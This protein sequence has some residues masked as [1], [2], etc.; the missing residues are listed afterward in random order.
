M[1]RYVLKDLLKDIE[2]TVLSGDVNREVSCICYDSRDM[3]AGAVFVCIKGANNDS[4]NMAQ[5]T[6][7]Y[8]AAAIVV[9]KEIEIIGDVTVILVKNTRSALSYMSSV[10]FGKPAKK[11]LMIGITGTKGK[12]TT[13]YMIEKILNSVGINTGLIGSIEVRYAD[14]VKANENTTPESYQLQEILYN[15]VNSGVQAVVME[16]SSQGLKLSRVD[17]II[18]DYAIF[19]NLSRDH[20][21]KYEHTDMDEYIA[22]KSMLFEQSR[23]GIFNSDDSYLGRMIENNTCDT[24]SYYGMNYKN[25]GEGVYVCADN[26]ELKYIDGLPGVSF[27]ISIYQEALELTTHNYEIK[28]PGIYSVYNAMAAITVCNSILESDES[29]TRA[30]IMAEVLSEIVVKGRSEVIGTDKGY[31][32]VVDFAHNEMSLNSVLTSMRQYVKGRLICLFGCGGNRSVERRYMMGE[33]SARLADLTVVT[34]DN[35]RYEKP[36]NI[37]KDIELGIL[38]VLNESDRIP[39]EKASF[40]N[41]KYVMID[42]RQKAIEVTLSKAKEGDVIILAGKGHETYQDIMGIKYPMQDAVIVREYLNG[43]EDGKS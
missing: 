40:D 18:F 12:T 9:E 36:E 17:G 24:I 20:I 42:D 19:T 4:H 41:G 22:C 13:S 31:T 3:K 16:V 25:V 6:V 29:D 30:E 15:M 37:M 11:M 5:S 7:Y 34:S 8:G 32:V 21:G 10:Y 2:Y 14:V 28:L 23:H 1:E 35:P 39:N 43:G 27:D 38:K 33:T 26:V